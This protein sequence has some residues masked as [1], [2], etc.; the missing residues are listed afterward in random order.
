VHTEELSVD[1][2]KVCIALPCYGGYVPLEMALVFAELVPELNKYGVDVSILAERGNSLPTTARNNLLAKFMDTKSDYIFWIDD[3]ILFQVQDFLQILALTVRK[4]SVAATYCARKDEPV[5]F[6]KP[7]DGENITFSPEGLIESRGCGL[8][9]SCQHRSILEPLFDSAE[10]YEDKN[11]NI[12]RDVFKTAIQDG[13]FVGEDYYF[14][15]ELY[16]K[17]NQI[18]YIHPLI[19]LKHVGRKDYDYRLLNEKGDLNGCSS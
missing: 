9:F 15:N 11:K 19:N 13:R 5:F 17:Q 12:V 4:K 8:G 16:R 3:D 2:V 10:T 14:F 18:T 1:G 6:I 7:I